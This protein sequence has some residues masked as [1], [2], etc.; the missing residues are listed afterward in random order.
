MIYEVKEK[1]TLPVT[2]LIEPFVREHLIAGHRDWLTDAK[3]F[4]LSHQELYD[5]MQEDFKPDDRID[6]MRLL[7]SNVEFVFSAHF[8]PTPEYFKPFYDAVLLYGTKFRKIYEIL[9]YN[10]EDVSILPPCT[11]KPG[12][13]VKIF[14]TKIPFEY[15]TRLLL[16]LNKDRWDDLY[17]FLKE[18]MSIVE[19]HR[20]DG[21]RARKLRRAFGGTQYE[22]KKFSVEQKLQHLQQMQTLP[23]DAREHDEDWNDALAV[24]TEDLDEELDTMLAALQQPPGKNTPPRDPLV[25]ITKIL[26]GTCTK[27]GC[28]YSHKEDM[29]AKKRVQY[30][31][32]IQKQIAAA[33]PS[34]AQRHQPARVSVMEDIYDDPEY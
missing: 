30:M 17:I 28:A 29:V 13:L 20:S 4:D 27:A 14:V 23:A 32:L 15:G 18:F 34:M 12:G 3:F 26:Y 5:L 31:E 22:A 6:F 7:E 9:A 16:L 33:K 21:E 19:E 1:T 8:R 25:C 24:A 10:C 11:N 2:S